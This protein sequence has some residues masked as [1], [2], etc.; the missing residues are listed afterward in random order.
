MYK[1]Q[2]KYRFKGWYTAKTGGTEV[3]EETIFTADTTVYAHWTY[4]GGDGSSGD[5]GGIS[6]TRYTVTFDTQGG[7]EIESVRVTRNSTVVKPADPTREGYTFEGWF[8]DPECSEA[9]DFDTKVTKNITLYAKWVEKLTDPADPEDW[10]NPFDDVDEDD[11][12]YDD[13]KNAY[14]NGWFTGVTNTSFAPNEAITRGMMVTVLYR[15]ENEPATAAKSKFT[16]VAP[17][18]Y[19]TKAVIWAENNGIIRGYSE[20]E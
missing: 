13:V 5:G 3:T 14:E 12:F 9:Y 15:A 7:N 16:D 6:V 8:T 11:W 20:V 4:T 17:D 2:G 1:R 19:Y 18:A 10:E